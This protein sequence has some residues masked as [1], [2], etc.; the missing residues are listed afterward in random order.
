MVCLDTTFLADLM[1]KDK[2]ANKKL[3]DLCKD[4]NDLCTTIIN[5]AELYYGAYKS[6]NLHKEKEKMKQILNRF[7]VLEMDDAG[8]EKFGEIKSSLAKTG[9]LVADRDV[10]TAAI[11]LAKGENF[12][13]TRNMKDFGRIP[14]LT[15]VTY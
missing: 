10:L 12:I 3:I 1:R 2:A 14:H 6:N 11:L 15:V 8:A 5:I 4:N 7:N 9:Q 13:V